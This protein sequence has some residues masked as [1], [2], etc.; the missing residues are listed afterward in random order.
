MPTPKSSA[1][2]TRT[3]RVL[4]VEDNADGRE[5]L[6]LLLEMA[7]HKVEVAR[8]GVEGLEVALR[9]HPDVAVTDIGLPR[10]DGYGLA[11]R[12]RAVFG[13]D[14]FLIAHTSYGQP[15]DRRRA[16]VAGFNVH[17]TKPVDPHELRQWLDHV[18]PSG[19]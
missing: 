4:I 3:L 6:R 18:A 13:P 2:A 15:E 9:D 11:E 16:F 7:G 14:I 10:L 12:L 1:T 17:L 8:D 5:M 19:S